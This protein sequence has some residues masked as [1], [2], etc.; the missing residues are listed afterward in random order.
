MDGEHNVALTKRERESDA[1]E[2]IS[3][4]GLLNKSFS[5]CIS[6]VDILYCHCCVTYYPVQLST[7]AKSKLTSAAQII[8]RNN[9]IY[10]FKNFRM[11][12]IIAI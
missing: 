8:C 2:Y 6:C 9:Y 10:L 5:A 12:S 11:H 3:W 4:S 7:R 1:F